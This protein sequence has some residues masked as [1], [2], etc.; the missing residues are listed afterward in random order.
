MKSFVKSHLIDQHA[1]LKEALNQLND[2]GQF[3]TLFVVTTQNKLVGS[4][5]DGDI[6]RCLLSGQTVDAP[7]T[8]AMNTSFHA[9]NDHNIQ[10]GE[11]KELRKRNIKLI[12][13]VDEQGVIRRIIN[14]SE[15]CSLLPLDA[16][17]M[18]GGEGRRLRPLTEDLPK[19]L[20]PVGEKPIME[21]NIDL[22]AKY[23]IEYFNVS[24]KYL[25]EKIRDYF[26]D[27]SAKGIHISYITE[28]TPLG[29]LGAVSLIKEFHND[30]V[31]I[32]NSDLL[33]NIDLE[34][35]YLEFIASDADMAIAT[36]PYS[37]D[38][39]YAVLETQN[40][41]VVNF[42]EKPT[43]TFYS[44]AGIYLV[45]RKVLNMLP[46][47]TFYNA[48]DLMEDLIR[49]SLKVISYPLLGYWLDIGRMEDY[50][51]AQNDIKHIII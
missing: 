16:V 45:K 32:M 6:R 38:I 30:H 26:G 29:T 25:G 18:A 49:Q 28:E 39:P 36:I 44:N 40:G 1:S 7:V 11:V 8:Q 9:L 21:H 51:K 48:T 17:I 22:L 42:K 3:L 47:N 19:P 37:V 34:D 24:I 33:T 43:Y 12:P 10:I 41:H 4:L 15:K 31:L 27:G 14:L 35:F 13:S 23:G 2:L 20:L 5:T 50:K 46:S